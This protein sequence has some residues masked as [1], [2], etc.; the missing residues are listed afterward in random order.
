MKMYM[1]GTDPI[2]VHPTKVAEM[3]RKGWSLENPK[4]SSKKGKEDGNS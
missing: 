3:E 4:P 1:K 2:D